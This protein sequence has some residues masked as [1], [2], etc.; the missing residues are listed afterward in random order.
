M[1]CHTIYTMVYEVAEHA[2]PLTVFQKLFLHI[3]AFLSRFSSVV[4]V[5]SIARS[6]SLIL[7]TF[8][9]IFLLYFFVTSV[10]RRQEHSSLDEIILFEI[11]RNYTWD[12]T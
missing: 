8:Q 7:Y 6:F 5:N 1:V 2:F 3:K 9:L 4:E 11:I 10:G 12:E